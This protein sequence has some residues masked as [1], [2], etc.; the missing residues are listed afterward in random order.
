MTSIRRR[1][2]PVIIRINPKQQEI[3]RLRLG[4]M[5]GKQNANTSDQPKN[6]G[7]SCG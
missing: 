1:R 4:P 5:T 6:R 3:K 7:R 2:F